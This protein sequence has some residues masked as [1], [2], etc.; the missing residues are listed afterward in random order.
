MVKHAFLLGTAS[1]AAGWL[2]GLGLLETLLGTLVAGTFYYFWYYG[3]PD[4]VD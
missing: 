4:E 1:G 2:V 3:A